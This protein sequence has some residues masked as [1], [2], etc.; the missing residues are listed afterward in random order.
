[1][2][3]AEPLYEWTTLAIHEKSSDAFCLPLVSLEILCT[4]LDCC[5]FCFCWV[6]VYSP[7]IFNLPSSFTIHGAHTTLFFLFI[8]F[9]HNNI[10]P[11]FMCFAWL[12]WL[13][14]HPPKTPDEHHNFISNKKLHGIWMKWRKIK[15]KSEL[16]GRIQLIS[17]R[18]T[19]TRVAHQ[20]ASV[21]I[22]VK[23]RTAAETV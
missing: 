11:K 13:Y 9:A 4:S 3:T 19:K 1:M 20:C 16:S 22:Y 8:Y 14:I 15:S 21:H 23:Q 6:C 17:L 12:A 5:W 18:W 7:A 10:R 2:S